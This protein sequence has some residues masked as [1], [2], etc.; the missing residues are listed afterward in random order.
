MGEARDNR[1]IPAARPRKPVPCWCGEKNPHR[2]RVVADGC[3]G[4]GTLLC[5]CGGDFCICHHHGEVE[6]PGCDACEG[7][8]T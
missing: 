2:E 6:C 4:L 5:L 7:G 3:N 1:L 8:D